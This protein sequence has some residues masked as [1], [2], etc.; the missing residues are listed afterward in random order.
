MLLSAYNARRNV[1]T[2]EHLLHTSEKFTV[3]I[4]SS[5]ITL[6]AIMLQKQKQFL[7]NIKK[8]MKS[9]SNATFVKSSSVGNISYLNTI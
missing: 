7:S 5:A 2:K 3:K 6:T 1:V 4:N 9:N 8:V